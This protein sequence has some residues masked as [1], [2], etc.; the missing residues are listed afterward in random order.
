MLIHPQP[1]ETNHS[2][3]QQESGYGYQ[4]FSEMRHRFGPLIDIYETAEEVVVD[5][6][7]P[8]LRNNEDVEIEVAGRYLF[9]RGVTQR[10][11]E[12]AEDVQYHLAER[13]YGEFYREAMLPGNVIEESARASYKN[14]VLEIRMKK[15]QPNRGT[16][17]KI[18]F[19][20]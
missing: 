6:E 11:N 17:I 8:G 4:P 20:H 7:L 3:R 15:A 10:A 13:S 5:C 19:Q 18:E 2:M 16:K 1:F 12:N 14:G 9:I